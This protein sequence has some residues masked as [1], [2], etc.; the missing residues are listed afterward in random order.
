MAI[1]EVCSTQEQYSV[2]VSMCFVSVVAHHDVRES[3]GH[4][5]QTSPGHDRLHVKDA[6]H[7]AHRAAPGA[8]DTARRG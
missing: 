3:I 4:F 8:T 2:S 1:A 7:C 5:T 6:R